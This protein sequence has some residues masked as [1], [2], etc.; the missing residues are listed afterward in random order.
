MQPTKPLNLKPEVRRFVRRLPHPTALVPPQSVGPT[1]DPTRKAGAIHSPRA[2]PLQS[3]TPED[4]QRESGVPSSRYDPRTARTAGQSSLSDLELENL[5]SPTS[6]AT[7]ARH[8]VT[9]QDS[10]SARY[11]PSNSAARPAHV[12]ASATEPYCAGSRVATNKDN[13]ACAQDTVSPA[14]SSHAHLC[15]RPPSAEHTLLVY[16]MGSIRYLERC[17]DEGLVMN[18]SSMPADPLDSDPKALEPYRAPW[19]FYQSPSDVKPPTDSIPLPPLAVG[20]VPLTGESARGSVVS[21]SRHLVISSCR[22]Y[23]TRIPTLEHGSDCRYITQYAVPMFVLDLMEKGSTGYNTFYHRAECPCNTGF[24]IMALQMS[25]SSVIA[26]S[27]SAVSF[28]VQSDDYTAVSLGADSF[29]EVTIV[30]MPYMAPYFY[31][32]GALCKD[33][34][35]ISRLGVSDYRPDS[36]CGPL[37]AY[38]PMVPRLKVMC[39]LED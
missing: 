20:E 38:P 21:S 30:C 26:T 13:E 1:P 36:V 32:E 25:S 12:S 4:C 35:C 18:F 9:T 28:P 29:T 39:V 7:T 19:Q 10:T 6:P 11:P 34:T 33:G 22:A 14:Y 24:S 37:S 31:V 5:D 2:V 23:H 15:L 16:R 17:M 3:A 27:S 8:P